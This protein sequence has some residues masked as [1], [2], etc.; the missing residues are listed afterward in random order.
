[1][2]KFKEKKEITQIHKGEAH[3]FSLNLMVSMPYNAVF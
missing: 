2:N 1:M 3:Q